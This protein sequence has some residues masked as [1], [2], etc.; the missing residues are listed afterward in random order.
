MKK[1]PAPVMK[2]KKRVTVYPVRIPTEILEIL[3]TKGVDVPAT[4]R[5][6][7]KEIADA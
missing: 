7:L 4:I 6:I 2:S 3:R 5:N 1:K